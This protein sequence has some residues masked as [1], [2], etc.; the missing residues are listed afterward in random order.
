MSVDLSRIKS[1]SC[2]RGGVIPGGVTIGTRLTS[3]H[4]PRGYL[5]VRAE[6]F[7]SAQ[8]IFFPYSQV[9]LPSEEPL[10]VS[11]C[12]QE[13]EFTV[14]VLVTAVEQKSI[15][16]DLFIMQGEETRWKTTAVASF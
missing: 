12:A 4:T 5:S 10:E 11:P 16:C 6:L 8:Y 14:C 1:F 15:S 7:R 13:E 9:R 3:T 2:Q